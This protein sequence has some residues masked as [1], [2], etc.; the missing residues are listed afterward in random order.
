[1]IWCF[2]EFKNPVLFKFL[3]AVA[4]E[5]PQVAAVVVSIA[6]TATECC[7]AAVTFFSCGLEITKF[8]TFPGNPLSIIRFIF[9]YII[10]STMSLSDNCFM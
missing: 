10:L 4:L 6:D 7:E 2:G 1:M 5:L 8:S 9:M 3:Y